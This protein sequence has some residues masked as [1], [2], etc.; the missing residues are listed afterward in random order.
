MNVAHLI[1]IDAKNTQTSN[2]VYQTS[3]MLALLDDIYGGVI[4]FEDLNKHGD[5]GIGTF[6]KLEGEIM[7]FD[8]E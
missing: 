4:S 2:E 8:N 3:A 1:A 6:D 7:A 5:F